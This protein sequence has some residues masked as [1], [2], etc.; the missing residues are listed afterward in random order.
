[1]LIHIVKI[2][3]IHTKEKLQLM[4]QNHITSAN[5]SLIFIIIMLVNVIHA[6]VESS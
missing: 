6:Y 2:Q 4:E 3:D 1:M 5:Y